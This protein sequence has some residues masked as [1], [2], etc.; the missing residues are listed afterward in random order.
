MRFVIDE[1]GR[2]TE[3]PLGSSP[4]LDL[5]R[6]QPVSI[7]IVNHL[8]E[9][10]SVH[11]HGIEVEDSYVDGVA[12]FSGA[13]DHLAPDIAP[14]DSFVARFTPPRSGTFMYHTHMDEVRQQR[15]G[16]VG[17]LVVRDPGATPSPDEHTFLLSGSRRGD[18]AHSI[19]I[20]GSLH[21]DT[22]VL[23]AGRPARLRILSLAWAN[24]T[25]AVS[26]VAQPD[27]ALGGGP[28]AV[29]RW[30]PIAKD[31]FD[32]PGSAQ[33]PRAARQVISMGETYDF[34]F[35]PMRRGLFVLAVGPNPP[36]GIRVPA[37]VIVRVVLRAE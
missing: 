23:R 17:A 2:R 6:G 4:E 8:H 18:H 11:W 34:S 9:P 36:P 21:P 33:T 25:P 19:E 16:M 26:I 37:R 14:G 32:L 5:V 27:S 10:T 3:G 31:G 24:P 28:P 1:H 15:G 29:Q 20:N 12:G 35:T 30:T 13:G 22:V 7:T